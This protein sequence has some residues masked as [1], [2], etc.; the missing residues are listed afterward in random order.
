MKRIV[1]LNLLFLCIY[2]LGSCSSSSDS[3][4]S[5]E[6]GERDESHE[7]DETPVTENITKE[8]LENVFNEFKIMEIIK[9]DKNI[10]PVSSYSSQSLANR[11]SEIDCQHEITNTIDN[12]NYDFDISRDY[13]TNPLTQLEIQQIINAPIVSRT[14][15]S[16]KYFMSDKTPST[17]CD[18]EELE[19]PV[20]NHDDRDGLLRP[21]FYDYSSIFDYNG[22][23][24]YSNEFYIERSEITT[25]SGQNQENSRL[26]TK[27]IL[28]K[29]EDREHQVHIRTEAKHSHIENLSLTG[30][31][32]SQQGYR[33]YFMDGSTKY[34]K[35][36]FTIID[37][38]SSNPTYGNTEI[39]M[40]NRY[41]VQFYINCADGAGRVDGS[42]RVPFLFDITTDYEEIIETLEENDNGTPYEKTVPLY[43]KTGNTNRNIGN[44]TFILNEEE[45]WVVDVTESPLLI[46]NSELDYIIENFN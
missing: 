33:F 9:S 3:I 17:D 39:D 6:N 42:F 31:M 13:R 2:L 28:E 38:L 30:F 15:S 5:L 4:E 26:I 21:T 12:K 19:G 18:T 7:I 36:S 27:G 16:I 29:R 32:R 34:F 45:I 25:L 37:E 23:H 41:V 1:K 24:H 46:S 10:N 11:S 14:E 8:L 40:V 22:E 43:V 20:P 44:V 35:Y